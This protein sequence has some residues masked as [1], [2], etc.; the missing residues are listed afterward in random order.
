MSKFKK[1]PLIC[2][3]IYMCLGYENFQIVLKLVNFR[4]EFK[5]PPLICLVIYI[6]LGYENFHL[7]L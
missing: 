5:N 1:P 6:C 3:V 4:S 2:L 7:A